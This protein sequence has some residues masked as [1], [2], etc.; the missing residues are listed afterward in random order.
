MGMQRVS[1]SFELGTGMGAAHG[2]QVVFEMRIDLLGGSS[3]FSLY[4]NERLKQRPP[5][6]LSSLPLDV[7][8]MVVREMEE[9]QQ[10]S[11]F[12]RCPAAEKACLM[13]CCCCCTMSLCWFFIG[14]YA[15]APSDLMVRTTTINR[16]VAPHGFVV[17]GDDRMSSGKYLVFRTRDW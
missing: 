5:P 13:S 17:E 7:W 6:V 10:L 4:R 16:E 1:S 8:A 9:W 11:G 14:N 15:Q 12:Y 2:G 3:G